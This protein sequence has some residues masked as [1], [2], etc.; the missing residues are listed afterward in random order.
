MTEPVSPQP[1]S[2]P[3]TAANGTPTVPVY[4][5]GR[6][7][8]IYGAFLFAVGATV[9]LAMSLLLAVLVPL[10]AVAGTFFLRLIQFVAIVATTSAV[11]RYLAGAQFQRLWELRLQRGDVGGLIGLIV[12]LIGVGAWTSSHWSPGSEASPV[13]VGQMVE[14]A[15]PTIS[16]GNWQLSEHTGKVVL[17]DF[18]A[19]WC[20]PCLAEMPHVA[21]AY[22]R[23]HDQGLEVVGV[24]LDR[25]GRD[26]QAFLQDHP[27]PWEQI[28][29][30]DRV[31]NTLAEKYRI[32]G[33]PFLMVIGRDGRVVAADVRGP[34]I[35]AAC[36]AALQ[37][38][39]WRRDPWPIAT[40]LKPFAWMTTAVLLSPPWLLAV[41][42]MAAAIAGAF[43]ESRL[44]KPQAALPAT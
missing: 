26:L 28:Y 22:D 23:L 1:V 7:A 20:G 9:A 10:P 27:E 40:W 6:G 16:G 42:L 41:A 24:S 32:Q 36:E 43:L 17:V 25:S 14:I 15:G 34:E 30:G 18:W 19:T 44:R 38:Q 2:E 21:A 35:E 12:G 13:Q 8:L 37:G 29:F 11:A 31:E 4:S 33:I 5:G 3:A 39:A